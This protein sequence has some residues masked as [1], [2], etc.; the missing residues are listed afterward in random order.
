MTRL[1]LMLD[2][3]QDIKKFYSII[4]NIPFDVYLQQQRYVVNAHSIMGIFSLDL[5]KVVTFISEYTIEDEII[6]QLKEFSVDN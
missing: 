4:Q 5:S 1:F 6:E 3:I 2:K